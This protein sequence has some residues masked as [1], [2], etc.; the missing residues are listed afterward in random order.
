MLSSDAGGNLSD[1]D[2]R[3]MLRALN[4]P[5]TPEEIADFRIKMDAMT[6][7]NVN[8]VWQIRIKP[9]PSSGEFVWTQ[10]H[11]NIEVN[12]PFTEADFR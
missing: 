5:G 3:Q 11:E 2:L 4:R 12:K 6:A 1:S 10:K 9:K 7:T 8:G